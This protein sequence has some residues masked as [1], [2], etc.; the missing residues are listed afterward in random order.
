MEQNEITKTC[1]KCH[2]E[3]PIE[4]FSWR[5]KND[6]RRA[7]CK[8]CFNIERRKDYIKNKNK[9]I[10]QTS[11]RI[12]TYRNDKRFKVLE[13]LLLHPCVICG[14]NDPVVLEFDHV[15]AD[16]KINTI[17]N[18]VRGATTMV[19]LEI[20]MD[21][22]QVLCAN[23]HRRKTASQFGFYKLNMH[24]LLGEASVSKIERTGS[25]PVMHAVV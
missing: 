5:H 1:I 10:A 16:D 21:K 25:N 15:D 12:K 22:C 18:M 13:Y 7:E 11:K 9:Q 14:E 6:K 20:E 19:D 17:C 23:C 4:Q 2:Y 3:K 8:D 24:F